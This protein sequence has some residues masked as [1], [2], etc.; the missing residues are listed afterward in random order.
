MLEVKQIDP[1]Q[2]VYRFYNGRIGV[3]LVTDRTLDD[4]WGAC[5]IWTKLGKVGTSGKLLNTKDDA[6]DWVQEQFRMNP[7]DEVCYKNSDDFLG[8]SFPITNSQ[9]RKK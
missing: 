3:G 7:S 1:D 5:Y 6:F 2:E 4:K 8:L 9:R